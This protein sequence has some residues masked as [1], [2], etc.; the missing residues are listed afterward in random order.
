MITSD[1]IFF[2]GTKYLGRLRR[3]FWSGLL[4]LAI[5]GFTRNM[6]AV[7]P[8]TN[9]AP[10]ILH[11]LKAFRE[12][13]RVLYVAAHPDDENTEL[14]AY[15]AR[16]RDY[17]TAYLSLTR[18]DG[19]QNVLGPDFGEKLGVARTQ[20]LLA[21]RRIDGGRQY[22]SRAVDFGFSKDYRETLN[23][24]DKQ[25]VLSDVV[26][27][28]REFRPDVVITRF[29]PIPG[30]THGHHT[31]STVLALEAFKL[32]GDPK[33]FP[34]QG[35]QP[36]QPTRILWN[37]SNFQRD[38][39]SGTNRISIDA[40][41]TDPVSG[42][43]F[44]DIAGQSRSMHKTQGF[45]AFRSPGGNGGPR[46]ESFQFLDGSPA[47]NDILDGV[48]TTWN[49]VP[50][51]A[52][53]GRLTDEIIARFN[54][55]DLSASVP[56]LLN[57]RSNLFTLKSKDP[58]VAE[59][60]E[61][62]DRILQ[63]CLGL[64]VETTIANAEVVPGETM[65]LHSTAMVRS[66]FPVVWNGWHQ[67]TT[68]G[69][70]LVSGQPTVQD[71]EV[72][73]PPNTPLTQPYW[74]REEGTPGM[75]RVD[76]ASLIGRPENPPVFTLKH[77]FVIAGQAL[78]IP[79]EPVQIL[80]NSANDE[81]RRQ[82]DVI[83]PVSLE[84]TSDVRLF[85]PGGSNLVAVDIVATRSNS[86]GTLQL[87]APTGWEISP[88]KQVF[89]LG[90][91]GDRQ[92]FNFTVTAPE[93]ATTAKITASA[94]IGGVHYRNQREE[95]SYPHIPRQ[96]L[97]PVAT[98]KAISLDLAIR[99]K[100]IGYVAGAGDTVAEAIKQMGCDM[101]MLGGEDLTAN[102]LKDFDAVVIGVRAFNVRTDLVSRLPA[103]FAF[104]ES[105]GNVIEQYN[106]PGNDLKT[107]QFAPY[108]LHLSGD[109][110]TDENAAVTF[111]TP[112]HPVLNTPNKITSADFDGWIQE[113]G[114]YFPNQWDDH[115]TPILACNDAGESPLK[116][117]L[118]VA[119]YGKGYFVYTGL[120]FF[121]ELPAGVPGAYRLFAN[122]ISL[123][124]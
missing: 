76:D 80:T 11:E 27:V 94:E 65:K 63:N 7:E 72:V 1:T 100:K 73:L 106:R 113:R 14:I 93:L 61:Q 4:C 30:G 37:V 119:Q 64:S 83:P 25:E 89:S 97:Q 115:F 32:A 105:G 62:L 90:A 91:V 71:L 3:I 103:L 86:T 21:A 26:R 20:E 70:K 46:T 10:A 53:I 40:G 17:S 108:S 33:A 36:W 49:R 56:A 12:M 120:V 5:F 43:T 58:V 50:G 22:F 6:F 68:P 42:E 67:N 34:E 31:A 81:I 74:L 16:G 8:P 110:V 77:S 123:G 78:I 54:P 117:G 28:I 104:V 55:Q 87:E 19:G 107:D 47:T 112:E 15:L 51:G 57:L 95:I 18:G 114:I 85:A 69:R 59:K 84:F 52:E 39:I 60:T 45:G 44:A 82:L 102:R 41:G 124:K 66:S 23:I 96:L 75:F 109:R 35:L 38:K 121:R 79:V 111:L 88:A 99:G 24:W 118:L 116:G 101:T 2:D 9:A 92:T 29:S 13:G 48:D 122:L 98:L